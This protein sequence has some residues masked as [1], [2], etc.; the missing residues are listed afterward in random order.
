MTHR[1][2]GTDEETPEESAWPEGDIPAPDEFSIPE[3]PGLRARAETFAFPLFLLLT[4]AVFS[5]ALFNDYAFD[6]VYLIPEPEDIPES[7]LLFLIDPDEYG[8]VSGS[9]SWRPL[10]TLTHF[11]LDTML[12]GRHPGLS[13]AFNLLLHAT[14]GFLLFLLIRK[15][16]WLTDGPSM[17]ASAW[18]GAALFLVH[19]LVSEVVLSAGFRFD[20]LAL[21]FTLGCLLVVLEARPPSDSHPLGRTIPFLLALPIFALALL[22]KEIG[23]LA[24]AVAPLAIWLVERSWKGAAILAAMMV[25][26]FLVYTYFWWHFRWEDYATGFMGGGGRALGIANFMVS[27]TE[28]YL[29]KLF[30]PWPL[31]VDHAFDPVVSLGD[32]RALRAY[33]IIALF[34]AFVF[35]CAWREPLCLFGGAWVALAFLPVAQI[36]PIPDPVAE[37]FAFVPMA[38]AGLFAAGMMRM[39]ARGTGAV[40]KYAALLAICILL[41]LAVLSHKRGWEWQDNLTLNI[42]NWEV[43]PEGDTRAMLHLGALYQSAAD[44]APEAAQAE[45][46]RRYLDLSEQQLRRLL[47]IEPG[48]AEALRLLAV[49]LYRQGRNKEGEELL[50]RALDVEPHDP[51][52]R[53]TAEALGVSIPPM[54]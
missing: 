31:R 16:Q 23:V 20:L 37:R 50:R 46:S 41:P 5:P 33:A 52:I 51:R 3:Q 1:T 10:G 36:T 30:L 54:E 9:L 39:S 17:A 7:G 47:S 2:G 24:L 25:I 22:S 26:P 28:V 53:Q 15:L 40:P 29:N 14:C 6:S 12:F 4:L 13:H 49:N 11:A 32:G 19:P 44:R 18:F 38:G 48:N 21:L 27:A 42:A 45:E 8:P 35:I 43:A 34:A